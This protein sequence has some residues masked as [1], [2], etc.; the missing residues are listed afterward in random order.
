[1]QLRIW[2][3][4]QVANGLSFHAEAGPFDIYGSNPPRAE[5]MAALGSDAL[6]KICLYE[7]RGHEPG[8]FGARGRPVWSTDGRFGVGLMQ[9]TPWD[10]PDN[11]WDWLANVRSA[12]ALYG[13]KQA[14]AR[15]Y[16]HKV[17]TSPKF[18]GLVD[19]FNTDRRAAG[20]GPITIVVPEFDATQ[21]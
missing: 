3:D 5:V 14:M 4:V 7:N 18:L 16:R 19:Q 21:R 2:C 9:I 20:Q 1:G 6:R 15:G 12:I 11:V 10:N 17:E 13:T 8:Q